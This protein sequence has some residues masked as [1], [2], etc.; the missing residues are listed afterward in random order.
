MS[1]PLAGQQAKYTK[2]LKKYHEA[3]SGTDRINAIEKMAQVLSEAKDFGYSENGVTQGQDVPSEVRRK[4]K[5]GV[6]PSPRA[7]KKGGKAQTKE[8]RERVD[9]TD[10]LEIGEGDEYVYAFNYDRYSDR[11]KI[12]QTNGDVVDRIAQQIREGVPAKP[13]LRLTIRTHD[14][15]NLEKFLHSFFRY[16]K[17]TVGGV[18]KEWFLATRDEV[19]EVYESMPVYEP[20]SNT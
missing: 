6:N 16:K 10:A 20:T 7:A 12:G 13:V 8:K 15:Q 2:F 9:T 17:K 19:I 3:N 4:V 11:L 1:N 18:G 5:S 14:S